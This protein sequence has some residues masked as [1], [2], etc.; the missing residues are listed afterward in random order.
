M[1][2]LLSG[3]PNDVESG[4]LKIKKGT[5]NVLDPMIKY[6][7]IYDSTLTANNAT[8]IYNM[9]KKTKEDL[10]SAILNGY[11]PILVVHDEVNG[12][13]CNFP[14]SML[15]HSGDWT[16]ALVT[17]GSETSSTDIAY[18]GNIETMINL[19]SI[20]FV[21]FELDDLIVEQY[22][23]TGIMPQK[24]SSNAVKI[25]ARKRRSLESE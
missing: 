20:D 7:H 13:I 5:S 25:K 8:A 10:K 18:F 11:L 24:A 2:F 6:F 14:F 16:G 23:I 15:S 12:V 19:G 22:I 17:I 9:S 3:S 4:D 1:P 21:G